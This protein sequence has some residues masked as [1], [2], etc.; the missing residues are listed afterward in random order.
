ME[1]LDLRTRSLVEAVE[2]TMR[3]RRLQLT[4]SWRPT[5]QA[6][7]QLA[8]LSGVGDTGPNA[9]EGARLLASE[10]SDPLSS[11]TLEYG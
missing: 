9:L 2:L 4:A 7:R 8:E 3:E 1:Q 5:E 6:K 11:M 10:H